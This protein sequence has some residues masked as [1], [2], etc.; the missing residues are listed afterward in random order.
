MNKEQNFH[1]SIENLETKQKESFL[2]AESNDAPLKIGGADNLAPKYQVGKMEYGDLTNHSVWA[3][4]DWSQ[5]GGQKY[6]EAFRD[7]YNIF[8]FTKKYCSQIWLKNC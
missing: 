3:Q 1:I 5:G 2:L 7:G 8:P 6:W 4:S